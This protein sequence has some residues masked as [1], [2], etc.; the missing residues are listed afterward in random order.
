MTTQDC[1][2]PR[3]VAVLL[4]MFVSKAMRSTVDDE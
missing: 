3:A 4:V 1:S 2:D